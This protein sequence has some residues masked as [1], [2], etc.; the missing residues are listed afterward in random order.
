MRLKKETAK[1]KKLKAFYIELCESMKDY[2][3][4]MDEYF[5]N[6]DYKGML[7][8]LDNDYIDM[9]KDFN[10]TKKAIDDEIYKIQE[11]LIDYKKYHDLTTTEY[12]RI[13]VYTTSA[14]NRSEMIKV[15]TV[16]KMTDDISIKNH[17]FNNTDVF[18]F[19]F[20]NTHV[21]EIRYNDNTVTKFVAYL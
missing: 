9:L 7:F 6:N 5:D 13:A 3:L 8:Q 21:M 15:N 16:T 1:L 4:D 19:D 20:A 14:V 2:V 12:K 10:D 17:I 18:Y 11:Q